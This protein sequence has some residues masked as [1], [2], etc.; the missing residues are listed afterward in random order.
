MYELRYTDK[1]GREQK[2]ISFEDAR[3]GVI[4][5][6]RNIGIRVSIFDF[7]KKKMLRVG[8]HGVSYVPLS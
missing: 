6:L 5:A 8:T 1:E 4:H 3:D 2:I 7:V